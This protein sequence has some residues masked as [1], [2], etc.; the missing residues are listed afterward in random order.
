MRVGINRG[1]AEGGPMGESGGPVE[2]EA[3][4]RPITW[5]WYVRWLAVA[6]V[7]SQFAGPVGFLALCGVAGVL[8]ARHGSR[9]DGGVAVAVAAAWACPAACA[10]FRWWFRRWGRRRWPDAQPNAAPERGE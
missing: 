8:I 5:P 9:F 10:A 4:G 7:L 1:S 3:G 2:R 6:Y